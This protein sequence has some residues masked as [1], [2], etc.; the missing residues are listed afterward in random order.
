MPR[1]AELCRVG[2]SSFSFSGLMRFQECRRSHG[3][4][5]TFPPPRRSWYTSADH[6]PPRR[7]RHAR[8]LR[9]TS[10]QARQLTPRV[11]HIILAPVP[12]LGDRRRFPHFPHL[13]TCHFLLSPPTRGSGSCAMMIWPGCALSEGGRGREERRG[14]DQ[15]RAVEAQWVAWSPVVSSAVLAHCQATVDTALL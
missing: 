1:F 13:N 4:M 5:L 14:E 6:R 9:L 10:H 8:S 7:V 2:N 11:R 12:S 15:Q 3:L